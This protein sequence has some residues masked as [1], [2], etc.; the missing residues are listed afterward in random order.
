MWLSFS[1]SLRFCSKMNSISNYLNVLLQLEL[2]IWGHISS[3][4]GVPTKPTKVPAIATW[5]SPKIVNDLRGFWVPL[6]ITKGFIKHYGLITKPLKNI[7][8]K[9][10]IF[11]WTPLA[12]QAFDILKQALVN[13]PMLAV[14][15]YHK[16]FC[17]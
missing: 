9:C 10:T 1:K 15:N 6:V 17:D 13:A 7:L 5:P 11:H 3:V 2:N 12:Q 8:R 16:P 4:V 14:P